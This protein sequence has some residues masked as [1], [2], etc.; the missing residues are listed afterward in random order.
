LEKLA[1]E[2]RGALIVI[3]HDKIFLKNCGVDQDLRGEQ[4]MK[5]RRAMKEISPMEDT[6]IYLLAELTVLPQFL[7]E[8]KAILKESLRT[9]FHG[10]RK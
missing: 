1:T 10:Y 5:V 8:V 9:V 7:E 6:K 3:P 4:D 2:F